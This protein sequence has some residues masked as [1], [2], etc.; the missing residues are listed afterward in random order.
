MTLFLLLLALALFLAL[1]NLIARWLGID[2]AGGGEPEGERE[3]PAHPEELEGS[4]AQD[5]AASS[6]QPSVSW[7]A[8]TSPPERRDNNAPRR[9]DHLR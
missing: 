6:P 8:S 4:G 3:G 1:V 5:S 2:I 7:S 9:R